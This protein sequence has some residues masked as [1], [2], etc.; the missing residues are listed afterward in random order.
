MVV[1]LLMS[2]FAPVRYAKNVP[3]QVLL[4]LCFVS[5]LCLR[6]LEKELFSLDF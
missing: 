1:E 2:F 3:R 4:I 6:D 5:N